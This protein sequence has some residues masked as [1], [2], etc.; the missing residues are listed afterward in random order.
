MNFSTNNKS[1]EKKEKKEENIVDF[2][3][4]LTGK[5]EVPEVDTLDTALATFQSTNNNN[6]DDLK[7]SVKVTDTDKIKEVD[8]HT[9]KP[10]EKGDVVAELYKSDTPSGEVIGNLTEGKIRSKDLKGPLQGKNTRELVRKIEKGEA[11]VD[12]KTEDKPKGK[13]RGKIKKLTPT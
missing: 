13:V 12:V 9:G 10:N 7:Y 8:I 2:A 3:A 4:I 5:E 1:Q 11:Y 6:K